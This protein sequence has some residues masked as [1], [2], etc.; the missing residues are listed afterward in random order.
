ME[1]RQIREAFIN[2]FEQHSHQCIEGSSLIPDNDPTLLFINAGM[3]QFKHVFMGL[4][5]RESPRAVTVQKCVRAGGKHN[6]LEKVGYTARHHTFFEMLGNFSFGDYFKKEAIHYAWDFL[7]QTLNLPKDRLW[8]TVFESDDEAFNIWHQQEGVPKDRIHRFGEKD[9]FWRMGDSGPCGPCSEVYYDLGEDHFNSPEDILGGEGD[10]YMEIWNLVFMQYFE[11]LDGSQKPL[12]NPSIDTGAGLERLTSVLQGKINNYD[13]DLFQNLISSACSF[14]G[15]NFDHKATP[16]SKQGKVNIALKVLADHSRAASFL[17]GDGV[18]P[19]NEGRGYVLRRILRRAIRY[20]RQLV[21]QEGLLPHV[22]KSVITVM[23]PVYQELSEKEKL[24][25]ST[26]HDEEKRFLKTLDQGIYLLQQALN[27]LPLSGS[28]ILSGEAAFK[29][30]DTYGFPIDLTCLIAKEQ[31]VG[32]DESGFQAHMAKAKEKAKASWKIKSLPQDEAYIIQLA[33]DNFQK[34]GATQFVGYTQT[35]HSANLLSLSNGTQTIDGMKAG[36]RGLAIFDSS[37]FYAEG[38]GQVGDSGHFLFPGGRAEVFD[39]TQKNDIFFH[40]IQV[41]E[42]HLKLEAKL[43][44]QAMES[45]RRDTTRNHSATHLMHSALR[46]VLGDHVTQAGS[47]VDDKHLRFD[48]THRGPLSPEEMGQ[49]EFLVNQE[50]SKSRDVK[51]EIMTPSE[52]KAVGAI[53]LF[54]E[55]YGDTVRVVGMGDFSMEFCGGTHVSNTSVIRLF[56]IV[57]EGS[58]SAG[59]RRI[60][61]LTG[62]SAVQYVLKHTEESLVAR[63][64]F[65]LREKWN[66]FLERK[67][68]NALISWGVK[69]QNEIKNLEKEIKKLKYQSI[70]MLQIL[71]ESSTF[72]CNNIQGKLVLADLDVDDRQT[73]R[74]I[75]DQLRQKVGSGVVVALGRGACSDKN[76]GSHP[77]IVNVTPNLCSFIHAGNLIKQVTAHV[78]GK[79]GG[80]PDSAQGALINRGD[81]KKAFEFIK[82]QIDQS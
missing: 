14:T 80:R 19:S 71:K 35:T 60:E 28:R 77:L 15:A 36:E 58:V 65:G 50:I 51:T 27:E 32:V 82:Q 13:I 21:E 48:F 75:S 11:D 57:N 76:E 37:C 2:Y 16:N 33:Q 45:K 54:G 18:I 42:G 25:V 69:H 66:H 9:N 68:E 64:H 38:G 41:T 62:D 70:D 10:R 29:L 63:Q 34:S 12:P 1:T 6:D 43:E 5:Q 20:G 56:K 49:I 72:T 7:T 26:V 3:N 23:G 46:R 81:T 73:L 31:E 24:I 61:A 67:Q 17:I 52:A 40:H 8:I 4:E 47:L 39:C 59:V 79:G 55:K 22:V 44:L 74:E 78:G 53:S 30:Y